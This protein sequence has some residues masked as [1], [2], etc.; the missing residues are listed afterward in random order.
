MPCEGCPEH[1]AP[2]DPQGTSFIVYTGGPPHAIFASVAVAIPDDQPGIV[3]KWS[4]PTIHPDGT[5][6]Y[7]QNEAEPPKIE[8]YERDASNPQLLRPIWSNCN[9]RAL[10]VWRTD[11]GAIKIVAC[12]LTPSSGL[13]AHEA[14]TLAHCNNCQHQSN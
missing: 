6:E 10:R 9:W 4:K 13:K 12:C 14:L 8:G 11:T 2:D 1:A 3:T 5:I 7:Q